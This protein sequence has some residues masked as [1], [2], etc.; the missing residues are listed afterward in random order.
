[1]A[2]KSELVCKHFITS[3]AEV[4]VFFGTDS[5]VR[6]SYV[7]RMGSIILHHGTTQK[8]SLV[9]GLQPG[10]KAEPDCAKLLKAMQ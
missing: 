3:V 1:M 2:A 5:L 8:S 4:R 6:C 9:P 7:S 10:S